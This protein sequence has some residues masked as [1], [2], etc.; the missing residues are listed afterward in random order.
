MVIEVVIEV[1]MVMKMMIMR[2]ADVVSPPHTAPCP[3][4]I[5]PL[6]SWHASAPAKF[7]TVKRGRVTSTT[8]NQSCTLRGCSESVF[9]CQIDRE[10]SPDSAWHQ[11]TP[12]EHTF[13]VGCASSRVVVDRAS[14]MMDE[15]TKQDRMGHMPSRKGSR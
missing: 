13:R 11:A 3:I 2:W 12:M 7:F 15:A 8:D 14:K 5:H 9:S 10:L 4:S 1:V 6:P